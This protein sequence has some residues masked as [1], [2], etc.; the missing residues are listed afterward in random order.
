M[1]QEAEEIVVYN[2][3]EMAENVLFEE[4]ILKN[5]FSFTWTDGAVAGMWNLL[6]SLVFNFNSIWYAVSDTF[7]QG[8]HLSGKPRNAREFDS[9]LGNVRDFN[10]SQGIVGGKILAIKLF[11]VSCILASILDF[12]ELECFSL[13]SDQSLLHSYPHHW[14]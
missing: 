7:C 13:V 2:G 6:R 12:A 3:F 14:Q 10:K 8:D 9:C 1:D 5:I 11:I 4:V